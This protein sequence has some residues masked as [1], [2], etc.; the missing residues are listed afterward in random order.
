MREPPRRLDVELAPARE[1][2]DEHHAREGA[3]TRRL[4]HI[5]GNRGSL[6]ALEGHFRRSCLGRMT[7]VFLV[8]A[9]RRPVIDKRSLAHFAAGVVARLVR[10]SHTGRNGPVQCQLR[11]RCAMTPDA[12]RRHQLA[13]I[14]SDAASTGERSPGARSAP[15]QAT[16][17]TRF[18]R[19]TKAN[20]KPSPFSSM[21]IILAPSALR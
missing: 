7:S 16:V 8:S 3:R 4:G 15:R 10:Q 6:I 20:A 11:R 18:F 21:K 1:M 9:S 12:W 19:F 14:G 5:S 2:V 13:M 17:A